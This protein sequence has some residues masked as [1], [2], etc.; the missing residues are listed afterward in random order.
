LLNV[1][2]SAGLMSVMLVL[3]TFAV[4]A[5]LGWGEQFSSTT[6]SVTLAAT[7]FAFGLS[8]LGIWEIPVPGFGGTAGGEGYGGAFSKGVLSTLLATP[9]SGPFLGSALAWAIAQPAYLTYAV[10]A[11]VGLG[12]AS[13]YLLVGLFPRLV[14]CLPRPGNW[15]VTFKQMMG[16]VLLATVVYL[17]SFI[18][19]PSVVPTVLVLLGVGFGCWWVGR[20]LL[21]ESRGRRLRAW[22]VAAASVAG[23]VWLSFGWLEGVMTKRFE[24][25]VERRLLATTDPSGHAAVFSRHDPNGI[26]W[27]SFTKLRLEELVN[28]GKTVF[29]DF[30]ADWCLTCKANEAAAIERPEVARLIREN[31]VVALRADKTKPAPEVDETLRRLGNKAASIPFYA[32]FPGNFTGKPILLD[33]LL[34]SPGPIVQA[35]RRAG[36]SRGAKPPHLGRTA[37][38]PRVS[39]PAVPGTRIDPGL[40]I[41]DEVVVR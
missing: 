31:G 26:A 24:R 35:F 1:A 21:P 30:T 18:S 14:R 10:F 5:G 9:C 39:R 32:I 29:V 23:T 7:V 2:Y 34:T 37:G 6:F 20:G 38:P 12:M 19:A 36:P 13:P 25:T 3:A 33:G 28:G 4:F 15:M 11:L 27:E 17:L 40:L 22:G 8:F 41:I 16:F